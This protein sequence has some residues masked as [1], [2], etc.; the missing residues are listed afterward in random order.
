L[1][2]IDDEA[3]RGED[4]LYTLRRIEFLAALITENSTYDLNSEMTRNLVEEKSRD[5]TTAIVRFFNGALIYF[6]G[7]FPG[8]LVKS[9]ALGTQCYDDAQKFLDVAIREYDQAVLN[10]AGRVIATMKYEQDVNRKEQRD[11]KSSLNGYLPRT[12]PWK[13]NCIHFIRQE[14]KRR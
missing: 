7:T 13:R 12:D 2:I 5:L 10:L 4:F 1:Q 9:I 14:G 11:E 3:N 8:N 6:S